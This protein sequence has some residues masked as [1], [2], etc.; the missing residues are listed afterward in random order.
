MP[1]NDVS[2]GCPERKWL[3]VLSLTALLVLSACDES[4][5]ALASARVHQG[6]WGAAGMVGPR[7][8]RASQSLEE[9]TGPS[10]LVR[11]RVEPA[12]ANCDTGGVVFEAGVDTDRDGELEDPEVNVALTR[13]ICNGMTGP[14]G[15]VGQPGP[16]GP[17]GPQGQQGSAGPP[18]P[19]GEQG[20]QGPAGQPGPPG[21]QGAQGPPGSLG[22]YGD[23][24][25]GAFTLAPGFTFDLTSPGGYSSLGGRQHLQFTSVAINGTLIVPSGT[26]IRTT[27]DFTLGSTGAIFVASSAEDT[28]AGPPGAG[29]A[30][31]PAGEPQAG[32][33]LA[34]LQAAQLVRPGALGGGAGARQPGLGGGAGGGSLVILAAGTVRVPPGG[35]IVANGEPGGTLSNSPGAGGGAGGVLVIV[36][37]TAINIGGNL[38]ASGGRGGDGNSTGSVGRGGGGGGGGGIIH[39]LSSATPTVTG[40]I[41]VNGGAAGFT[42]IPSGSTQPLT[43]GGGGGAC[44]GSGGDGGAGTPT[45]PQ[46][47]RSGT[48]GYSLQTVTPTPENLFL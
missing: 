2:R 23:G 27:G 26:V 22:A 45:V 4:K 24:S 36:G 33:G 38:R 44:G 15:P 1:R 31:A 10:A 28:G 20:P 21:P 8:E 7:E 32:R 3:Q 35:S 48:V 43:A 30:R 19:Q 46:F 13:Y 14:Q 41:D 17:P 34:Q 29:V 37:K 18:G 39:L 11:T 9:T 25:G 47:S 16:P 6:T 5:G 40:F 12:G 42:A